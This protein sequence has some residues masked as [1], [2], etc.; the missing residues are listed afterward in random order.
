MAQG[1][2]AEGPDAPE[3]AKQSIGGALAAAQGDAGLI[4]AARGAFTSS[5]TTTFTISAVGVLAAAVLATL[6]MRDTKPAPAPEE[7]KQEEL[8]A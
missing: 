2:R 8:A 3:Q 6:V 7:P 1:R 4:A 5:M